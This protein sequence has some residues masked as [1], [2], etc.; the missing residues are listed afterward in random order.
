ME[1]DVAISWQLRGLYDYNR[2]YVTGVYVAT[3][4]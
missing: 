1:I 2:I 4:Q 3:F